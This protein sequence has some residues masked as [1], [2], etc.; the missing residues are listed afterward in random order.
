M[1]KESLII[2]F[3][4]WCFYTGKSYK[5]TQEIVCTTESKT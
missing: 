3:N 4:L 5:N 1:F 2:K